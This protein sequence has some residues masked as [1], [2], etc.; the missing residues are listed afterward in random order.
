MKNRIRILNKFPL[1]LAVLLVLTIWAGTPASADQI[2]DA[3]AT[4]FDP[5]LTLIAACNGV[6][7]ATQIQGLQ[8][9]KSQVCSNFEGLLDGTLSGSS[10]G[11]AIQVLFLQLQE[12]PLPSLCAGSLMAVFAQKVIDGSLSAGSCPPGD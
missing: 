11:Y 3:L 7:K 9:I 12:L 4:P 5:T 2:D 6:P 8:L 1:V 10:I